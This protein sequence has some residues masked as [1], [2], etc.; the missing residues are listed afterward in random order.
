MDAPAESGVCAF[1][2]ECFV[3]FGSGAAC[4]FVGGVF[5]RQ[6]GIRV[7]Y[8]TWKWQGNGEKESVRAK[9]PMKTALFS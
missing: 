2:H 8:G 3:E 7:W 5:G 9:T 1:G 6:Y 4:D